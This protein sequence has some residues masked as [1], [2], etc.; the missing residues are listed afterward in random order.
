VRI[1]DKYVIREILKVF[2]ICLAGFILVFL[3]VEITDKIKYYFEYNPS[4]WLMLLYF[5][6]KIPGYLFFA[7]PLSILIGGMLGLMLMAR[8]FELIA[9]QANGLDA[10]SIARPVLMVGLAAS[11]L[12]FVANESIIPWS[13]KYSE[14]VQNVLIAGKKDTT[15][16]KRDQLWIRTADSIVHIRNF[17]QDKLTLDRVSIVVWDNQYNFRERIFADKARWWDNQWIFYGV[18]RTIRDA[19]GSFRVDHAP[20]MVGPLKKTPSDF[21]QPEPQVKEMTL[22]QLGDRI[23]EL[24]QEGQEPTRYLVDWYDKTAFP[25]V[26][27]I[28]A[29]LSVPFSIKVDPRGGGVALGF[30]I[31]LAIAFSYW[32][33]HT[34][35]I[36]LGHGGYI[37]PVAAAWAT[38]TIFGLTAAILLLKACT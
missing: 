35:F 34:M 10:L 27:L 3:L 2:A 11:A 24:T 6:V 20:S 13:N 16:F 25:L 12:M 14:Y 33:A 37:P 15:L 22:S 36:A 17:N 8:H 1:I 38:N 29:A 7:I 4:G 18:I 21:Q 5:L 32:I 9:M 31:S 19:D 30:V 23:E 28:M 26:C